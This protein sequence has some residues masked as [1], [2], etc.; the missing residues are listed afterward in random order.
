MFSIVNNRLIVI[1]GTN[2]RNLTTLHKL[3]LDNSQISFWRFEIVYL[4]SNETRL[5]ALDFEMNQP[6][7]D[8]SCSINPLQ[9]TTNTVFNTNC[10]GWI[11][12]DDIKDYL[13]Y[14]KMNF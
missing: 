2:S 1:T 3:F 6:P 13:F 14:G 9:G 5:S 8:G 7:K 12:N 11:D 10:S 4:F